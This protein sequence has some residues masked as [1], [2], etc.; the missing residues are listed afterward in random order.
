MLRDLQVRADVSRKLR[1][2]VVLE[3]GSVETVRLEVSFKYIF[4]FGV[5]STVSYFFSS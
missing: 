4:Y 3:Q 2:P 1:L 5:I